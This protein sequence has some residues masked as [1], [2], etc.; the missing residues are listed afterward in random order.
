MGIVRYRQQEKTMRKTLLIV[1]LVI[2]GGSFGCGDSG[3]T[4]INVNAR[5]T[6]MASNLNTVST[7]MMT[8]TPMNTNMNTMSNANMRNANMT[9]NMNRGTMGNANSNRMGNTMN[10]N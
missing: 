10:A 1:S 8:P 5:N 2:A 4:N 7:P 6:N 9:S 3:N